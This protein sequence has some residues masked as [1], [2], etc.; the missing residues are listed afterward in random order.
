M[1]SPA[2][3]RFQC[4]ENG[5]APPELD[6]LI[7]DG[8]ILALSPEYPD[9]F[10]GSIGIRGEKIVFLQAQKDQ[11]LPLPLAGTT[12]DASRQLVMPGLVNAHAHA[13]MSLFRG[14]ADD[15]PL[16]IW[17]EKHIF[18]AESGFVN[19]ES[20]YWG[21]LLACAEML[22]SG[23]TTCADGYFFMNEAAK[24]YERSGMRALLCQ[25]VL[26]FPIPGVPDPFQNI[27]EAVRFVD[28]WEGASSLLHTGIFCH[29][30]YTC[31]SETLKKVK[32]HCRKKG[33]PFYIHVAETG[34]EVAL[35]QSR[36]GKT[37]IPYLQALN[38][39]DPQTV[40]IH[41]VHL[42][43]NEIALLAQ[44]RVSVVHCPESNMKLA[45]GMAPIVE[46]M[47]N[48]LLVG[49]GT[50]SCASNNDLDL[51]KEMDTAAKLAKIRYMN[52]AVLKARQVVEMATR[53]GAEILGLK[54]QIGTLEIGK[55]ADL[56]LL[57]L[58]SPHLTPCYDPF[59]LLVYAAQGS[60]VRSVMISGRLVVE[61][62]K[63]M[64][65]DLDEVLD[66]VKWLGQKIS[67]GR[68]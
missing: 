17:L 9:L 29:S 44:N 19:S 38:L 39:L 40:A 2:E 20:V 24:A 15:L 56:I 7:R 64:S 14:L 68:G 3:S 27:T 59:S 65:F 32:A 34:E 13:A 62:R 67:Q 16:N 60:D 26:D 28:N 33:V 23:T 25:G 42:G 4:S 52:P 45:S 36:E 43:E 37:P 63:I 50:D 12:I 10:P 18:P 66:R 5:Q 30:P 31:S 57:D 22:L 58:S 54:H 48:G 55:K 51:I 46:M 41:A 61:D 1:I 11:K 8:L 47:Q 49:L 21:T 35:V 53:N 6:F